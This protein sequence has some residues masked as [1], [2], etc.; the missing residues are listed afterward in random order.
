MSRTNPNLNSLCHF[1][2][3]GKTGQFPQGRL[4]RS[5]QGLHLPPHFLAR[6]HDLHNGQLRIGKLFFL[7]TVGKHA[8][9]LL[10]QGF[11]P[12]GHVKAGA[13]DVAGELLNALFQA[14][15][16]RRARRRPQRDPQAVPGRACAA[17]L[18]WASSMAGSIK[19][20]SR[21][22]TSG[23]TKRSPSRSAMLGS[24][25]P[26]LRFSRVKRLRWSSA[27][28][29]V[30]SATAARQTSAASSCPLRTRTSW[31]RTTGCRFQAT[32]S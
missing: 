26:Y 4:T 7:R 25:M 27:M 5:S 8:I 10:L 24:R 18:P 31:A 9:D 17:G 13:G 30:R 16:K 3:L 29:D 12:G 1:S 11:Q 15:R 19:A 28:L 20:Q 23:R 21:S 22:T 2:P 32:R 6:E 14:G